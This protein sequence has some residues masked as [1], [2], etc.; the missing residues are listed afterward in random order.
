[1]YD[2]SNT[3]SNRSIQDE[4]SYVNTA[5][6]QLQN[7]MNSLAHFKEIVSKFNVPSQLQMNTSCSTPTPKMEHKKTRTSNLRQ[8]SFS[9]RLKPPVQRRLTS[10][11]TVRHTTN[12]Y[13]EDNK[14][15]SN[16]S[17]SKLLR[18]PSARPKK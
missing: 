10:T 8:P 1:N 16:L 9:S 2:K 12:N 6:E 13:S 14:Y 18:T 4:A 5:T 7:A 11:E 15:A 3:L 17:N